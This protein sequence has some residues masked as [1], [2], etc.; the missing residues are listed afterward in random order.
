MTLFPSTPPSGDDQPHGK[1]AVPSE[2][3]TDS[4]EAWQAE[5]PDHQTPAPQQGGYQ[6]GSIQSGYQESAYQQG[7]YQQGSIQPAY[8]QP[9]YQQPGYQQGGY[10]QP[11]YQQPYGV[12]PYGAPGVYAYPPVYVNQPKP[13]GSPVMGIVGLG[14]AVLALVVSV[15][16]DFYVA[17][18]LRLAIEQ[19][20]EETGV[21]AV[22]NSF[23]VQIGASVLGIAGL[24]FAIVA[25][26]TNKGRTTGIFGIVVA[27]VAPFLSYFLFIFLMLS[28]TGTADI[29]NDYLSPTTGA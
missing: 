7:G 10:Q 27:A 2:E 21:T 6:Q 23:V 29:P 3:N 14:L 28:V 25:T 4:F 17:D 11:G 12:Q 26:S 5:N 19:R 24:V 18:Q 13:A 15:I 8:Q 1:G 20:T 9:S 22:L 16:S